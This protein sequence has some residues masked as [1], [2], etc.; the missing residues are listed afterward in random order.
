MIIMTM[1]LI[2]FIVAAK[3][4]MCSGYYPNY[5]LALS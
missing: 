5:G 4:G 3:K 2:D 1:Y